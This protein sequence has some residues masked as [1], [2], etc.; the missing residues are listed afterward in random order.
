[1]YLADLKLVLTQKR[2]NN[3]RFFEGGK[4]RLF[5]EYMQAH[6]SPN[7]STLFCAYHVKN[8][9]INTTRQIK[10]ECI[11]LDVYR[12]DSTFY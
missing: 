12:C 3:W 2:L 8:C 5:F 7:F 1:M 9:L 6:K 4:T 10:K 11:S